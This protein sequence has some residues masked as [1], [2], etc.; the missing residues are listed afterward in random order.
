MTVNKTRKVH[1]QEFKAE[2]LKLAE[3]AEGLAILKKAAVDSS[4]Q[5]NSLTILLICMGT[6]D[7]TSK[8]H[9]HTR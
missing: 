5:C 8:T 3:Q 2:A 1:T 7:E 4:G 9:I 6:S